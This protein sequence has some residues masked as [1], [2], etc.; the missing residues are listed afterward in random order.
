MYVSGMGNLDT[1]DDWTT[2]EWPDEGDA[3]L[4][5]PEL[6]LETSS[7]TLR[8]LWDGWMC[9][10]GGGEW[11]SLVFYGKR[12]GDVPAPA[13]DAFV[14][15][16][17]AL[18]A[19]GLTPTS[20][21]GTYNCRKIADSDEYSLH[22]AGIAI[23][24]D[25]SHNPFSP[26]DKYAGTI[27]AAQVAEVLAIRNTR[28]RQVFTWGGNWSKP[29]R[30]HFQLDVGPTETEIDWSTVGGGRAAPTSTT[31][32]TSSTEED[33][34]VLSK[35]QGGEAVT[36][37]QNM[38]LAWDPKSLPTHGADGDYGSETVTAVKAFQ[39]AMGLQPTGNIDG[40]TA[41]MLALRR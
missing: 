7:A 30:M 12:I 2:A 39:E 4:Q 10:K 11:R 16:G 37:F 21:S 33:E 28:G 40:V 1:P 24:V 8:T 5:D 36:L 19:T 34:Q 18:E 3:E 23:D 29:D 41:A 25:W 9:R 22:S 13:H 27:K 32:M 20:P 31:G 26:G 17:A 6:R 38:L 35:G 14:A 15:L